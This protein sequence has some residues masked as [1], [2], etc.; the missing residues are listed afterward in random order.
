MKRVAFRRVLL[1]LFGSLVASPFTSLGQTGKSTSDARAEQ[2]SAAIDAKEANRSSVHSKKIKSRINVDCSNPIAKV[3]TIAD[4]LNRLGDERPAELLISG[5]C[6]ENVVIQSLDR[7]TLQG[8]PTATID[9]GSDPNV[10]TVEIGDSQ[11]VELNYLTITGGGEGVGCRGQSLCRLTHV[12]IQNG[13]GDGAAV[14]AGS[15]SQI[16]DTVIQNNADVGLFVG[17]PVQFSGGSVVGNA[18]DGIVLGNGGFLNLSAG[19]VQNNAGDGVIAILHNTVNMNSANITGNAGDGVSV[20]AGSAAR[21]FGSTITNNLGHQVR[22]GDLSFVLFV[23][24]GSNSIHGSNS[25]DVVC[26]P[27]FS[28]TRRITNLVGTTT[29]CP[30]ELP[31]TP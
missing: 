9:G 6:H 24:T 26:D 5:T 13:L 2:A 3:K 28:T 29:N 30:A 18:S 21:I 14:E 12:T 4:G 20:G 16:V 1:F 8:N 27:L 25:P 7:I 22:I 11:S 23:G 10:G 17:G 19:S 15:S 31:V